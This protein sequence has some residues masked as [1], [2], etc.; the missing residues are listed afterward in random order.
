MVLIG[1]ESVVTGSDRSV[2]VEK[3]KREK[4]IT[5]PRQLP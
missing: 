1:P 5:G 2:R 4:A 3:A